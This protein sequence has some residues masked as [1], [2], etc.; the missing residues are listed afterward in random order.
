M[1]RCCARHQTHTFVFL[2]VTLCKAL[3][4][5]T[6]ILLLHIMLCK[7]SHT[8]THTRI[9]SLCVAACY[10]VQGV[11]YLLH[12]P[13][14]T[15]WGAAEDLIEHGP[16]GSETAMRAVRGLQKKHLE[17]MRAKSKPDKSA[18]PLHHGQQ[19]EQQR[20]QHVQPS[21]SASSASANET[22]GR[23]KGS[24]EDG[25]ADAKGG[26]SDHLAQ[27]VRI[28]VL[29]SRSAFLVPDPSGMLS[30]GECFFQP[31]IADMPTVIKGKVMMVGVPGI[32]VCKG[33]QG[34]CALQIAA[35]RVA[36]VLFVVLKKCHGGG[37]A[38]K[39][40]HQRISC[41]HRVCYSLQMCAASCSY[42]FAASTLITWTLRFFFRHAILVTMWATSGCLRQNR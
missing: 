3:N 17:A 6:H 21:S 29:D 1:L 42:S 5:H 7:A 24:V 19:Q 40:L 22:A 10:A 37:C 33:R 27:R 39:L 38:C 31:T 18:Q 8:H 2:H 36:D 30:E 41:S 25:G 20:Q 9:H 16:K 15:Q 34:K 4:T 28:L 14:Q 26:T 11:P 12:T 35:P 13:T 32:N 23:G